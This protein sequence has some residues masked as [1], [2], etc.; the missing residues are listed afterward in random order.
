MTDYF[1]CVL[2]H[3]LFACKLLASN[4]VSYGKKIHLSKIYEMMV[5]CTIVPSIIT[6]DFPRDCFL[7]VLYVIVPVILFLFSLFLFSAIFSY[8]KDCDL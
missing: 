6:H 4:N 2:S 1:Y 8:Y 3:C 7:I 5:N